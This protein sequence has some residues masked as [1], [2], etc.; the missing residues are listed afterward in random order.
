MASIERKQR[1]RDDIIRLLA[2]LNFAME[3]ARAHGIPWKFKAADDGA[4]VYLDSSKDEGF[5]YPRAA[6][7]SKE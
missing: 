5:G 2:D 6:A 3:D 4:A 1:L 7:P